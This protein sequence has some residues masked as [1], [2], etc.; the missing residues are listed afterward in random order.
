M[1]F[2][3]NGIKIVIAIKNG[4][5][6]SFHENLNYQYYRQE[7]PSSIGKK[8]TKF[9]IFHIK[10][11]LRILIPTRKIIVYWN[12]ESK[13]FPSDVDVHRG[14]FPETKTKQ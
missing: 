12:A 5:L 2:A 1:S 4:N 10:R 3:S 7:K 13:K 9:A 11:I 6:A 8:T 14:L